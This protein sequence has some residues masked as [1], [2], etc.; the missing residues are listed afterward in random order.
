MSTKILI[1]QGS[2]RKNG[3]TD[4]LAGAMAAGAK[5]AGAVVEKVYLGKKNIGGC[6]E[7]YACQKHPDGPGHCAVKDDLQAVL[8]KMVKADV[9]LAATPVFCWGPSAQLKA[10]LDR[11]FCTFRFR[12]DGSYDC[13]LSGKGIALVTTAGGTKND[14]MDLVIECTRRW[15]KY[16]RMK[17]RGQLLGPSLSTPKE[18]AANRSL[19]A[20]AKA[21][22]RKLAR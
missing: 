12:A 7:C 5:A 21:F 10:L 20:R 11:M 16:S 18:T 4:R 19:L 17:W 13:L 15:Q 8:K 22:G 1:L 3:N 6:I 9:L 14:G 2:P